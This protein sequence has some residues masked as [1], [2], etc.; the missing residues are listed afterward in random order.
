MVGTS[1]P[2]QSVRLSGY[3]GMFTAALTQYASYLGYLTAVG[4]ICFLIIHIWPTVKIASL[5]CLHKVV[6]QPRQQLLPLSEQ[7]VLVTGGAGGL[8]EQLVR[9]FLHEGVRT[10]VIWEKNEVA[11]K[12]LVDALIQENQERST[13]QRCVHHVIIP[14]Q[15]DQKR[16]L[17]DI[18]WSQIAQNETNRIQKRGLN[19]DNVTTIATMTID[20]SQTDALEV[21][22]VSTI[23]TL[24]T[25]PHIFINNAAVVSA[26]PIA[27]LTI[28]DRRFT[29]LVNTEAPMHLSTLALKMYSAALAAS[30]LPTPTSSSSKVLWFQPQLVCIASAAGLSYSISLADYCASKAALIAF[31]RALR[32]EVLRGLVEPGSTSAGYL[33]GFGSSSSYLTSPVNHLLVLPWHIE[34]PLLHGVSQSMNILVRY[35]FPPL[36]PQR[37]ASTVVSHVVSSVSLSLILGAALN[38]SKEVFIPRILGALIPVLALLPTWLADWITGFVGGWYGTFLT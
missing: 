13:K 2:R 31:N 20:L 5:I 4:L 26:K 32:L 21:G 37:V 33:M 15:H 1:L 27:H 29:H 30:S 12:R 22:L 3:L 28:A 19:G 17:S 34:T 18:N 36:T 6:C 16:T 25:L 35:L 23:S 8:G 7:C 11:M 10:I 24:N 9:Q 14:P 38:T